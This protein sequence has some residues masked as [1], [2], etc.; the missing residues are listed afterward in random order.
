MQNSFTSSAEV[1][2]TKWI[3]IQCVKYI[4]LD[5]GR[6][7]NH[8]C[9]TNLMVVSHGRAFT[10]FPVISHTNDNMIFHA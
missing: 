2:A 8:F 1:R 6:T 3:K 4:I 9:A 10:I 7:K 5:D